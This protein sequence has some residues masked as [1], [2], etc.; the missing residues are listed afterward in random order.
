LSQA[1]T[2]QARVT[3]IKLKMLPGEMPE[4]APEDV[5]LETGDVVYIPSRDAESFYTG[6]LLFGQQL[7]LPRDYELDVIGAI[8]IAGGSTGGP[9]G[10]N[11]ASSLFT[12]N[13]GPGA[14]VPP[15]RVL[16]IRKTPDG[17]QV[18]IHVNLKT[19][20]RDGRERL[21]IQPGDVVLLQFT[22]GEAAVNFVLNMFRFNAGIGRNFISNVGGGQASSV[23]N[24][25]GP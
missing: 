18:A 5:V 11:G 8:A 12:G 22:P 17:Q 25:T 6:G 21:P 24:P 20:I 10:W 9:P 14:I 1:G 7:T 19:A 23:V 4:Y 15:T 2:E 13:G 3:R 16:V